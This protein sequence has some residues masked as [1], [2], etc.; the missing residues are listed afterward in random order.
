VLQLLTTSP[1][2]STAQPLLR[3]GAH[4]WR[5][6]VLVLMHG[7]SGNRCGVWALLYAWQQDRRERELHVLLWQE[8]RIMFRSLSDSRSELLLLLI[9]ATQIQEC[10]FGAGANDRAH[11]EFLDHGVRT[12]LFS[13]SLTCMGALNIITLVCVPRRFT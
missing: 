2:L 9:C 3:G 13:T 5:V 7:G 4:E 6:W 11:L 8:K 10:P 1:S 12:D